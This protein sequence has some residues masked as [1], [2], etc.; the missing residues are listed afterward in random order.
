PFA[1]VTYSHFRYEDYKMERLKSPATSDT[2][3]DYSGN[4]VA[5]VAPWM[6]NIG[7]DIDAAAGIYANVIYSFKDEM[8]FTSDNVNIA[9]SY[10]VLN[11]K[12]GIRRK[13]SS[14]FDLDVFVGMNNITNTQYPYMVFINQLPDAYLPAPYKANYFG[15]VNLKFNF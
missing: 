15:G 5:G 12:L 7:V 4:P 6:A 8:P 14:R 13:L 9:A 3:I 10:S 1:N 11:A 2:T